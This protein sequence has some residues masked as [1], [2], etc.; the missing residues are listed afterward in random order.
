MAEPFMGQISIFGFN[1]APINW[2]LC[3]GQL[4]PISQYSAVFSLLGTSF[5]GNGTTNFGLPNLQ[6]TVGVGQGS[7]PGGSTYNL[8]ASGGIGNVTL[9]AQQGSIHTHELMATSTG[10]T[11]AAAAG[12]VL[13]SPRGPDDRGQFAQGNIYNQ[14]APG[15]QITAPMSMVGGGAPHNNYQPYLTINYCI[16]LIGVFPTRP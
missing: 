15:T 9:G 4:V 5:G 16:C 3:Q 6:G 13:A 1:F 7:A 11:S 10:S 14:T 8:G 2:A 12:N